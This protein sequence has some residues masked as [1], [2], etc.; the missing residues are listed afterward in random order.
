MANKTT[1]NQ[2]NVL[3]D[4]QDFFGYDPS[5]Q[6]KHEEQKKDGPEGPGSKNVLRAKPGLSYHIC[7]LPYI[8]IDKNLQA[9]I[10]VSMH[11]GIGGR[12]FPCLYQNGLEEKCAA[13]GY[14]Q[15]LWS[16]YKTLRDKYGKESHQCRATLKN[17][18]DHKAKPRWW[19]AVK[20]V[21]VV[22]SEGDRVQD[23]YEKWATPD[24]VWFQF[25]QT[26]YNS[27]KKFYKT[28]GSLHNPKKPIILDFSR[29]YE[30][31]D[32]GE[33]S[34]FM[35]PVVM[36]LPMGDLKL[37][38]SDEELVR[39]VKSVP[40][41]FESDAITV[42]SNDEIMDLLKSQYESKSFGSDN[43]DVGGDENSDSSTKDQQED[44]FAPDATTNSSDEEN[45]DD[46]FDEELAS[47]LGQDTE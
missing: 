12:S 19:S 33:K 42:M 41:L 29:D 7:I 31:N 18:N 45:N 37:F 25:S 17:I 35:K 23:E 15:K 24:W 30:R 28:Y 11:Y 13:D 21:N 20:V 3:S 8:H 9:I 43:A 40:N 36:P 16:E 22:D 44:P 14:I 6:E 10:E 47:I 2:S 26:V 46:N 38:D 34:S 4:I 1:S 5:S 27:L 39:V 32:K